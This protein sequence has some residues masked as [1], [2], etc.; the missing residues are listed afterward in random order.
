MVTYSLLPL[1][2]FG[3]GIGQW[4]CVLR[5]IRHAD[6][7]VAVFPQDAEPALL[8]VPEADP[9]RQGRS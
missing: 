8:D 6:R 9:A 3:A 4:F 2:W 7:S 1:G 5:Q